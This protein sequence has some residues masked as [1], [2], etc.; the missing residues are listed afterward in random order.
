MTLERRLA[1]V[2]FRTAMGGSCPLPATVVIPTIGR[3]ELLRQ[4][5]VSI[6]ACDP[7]PDEVIVIDQSRGTGVKSLVDEIGSSCVRVVPCPPEGIAR[8]RNLGLGEASHDRVLMTDDD[9]TVASDWIDTAVR[10]SMDVPHR[11]VTGRVLPLKSSTYVPSTKSSTEPEDFTGRKDVAT[12]LFTNNVVLS[13]SA[14]LRIGGFDERKSMRLAAEDNDLC[15]R[16]L[17]SGRSLRYEPSLVVWHHD[18]RSPADLVGTHI[19]Y[20]RGQG[21][22]YAKHLYCGDRQ[23]LRMIRADLRGGLRSL[24]VGLLMRRD[25][26]TDP[27]REVVP[28]L[29]IGF[30][31]GLSEARQLA[32]ASR[33]GL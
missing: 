19:N 24:A 28:Y 26:S 31:H 18:W 6:L 10:L 4:C 8:A 15:Y 27:E 11:I 22:F 30:V 1:R 21:A 9:C 2:M 17:R 3:I 12:A 32:R 23:I 14:I 29:L 20:A 13:R 7:R 5:L 25:R 16:W 33:E